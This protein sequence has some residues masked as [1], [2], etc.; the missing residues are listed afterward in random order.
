MSMIFYDAKRKLLFT[1]ILGFFLLFLFFLVQT[2]TGR[3]KNIQG[4]WEWFL[5]QILPTLS[6]MLS[7]FFANADKNAKSDKLVIDIW[8]FRIC[9]IISYVYFIVFLIVLFSYTKDKGN[10]LEYYRGFSI[11]FSVFQTLLSASLGFFFVKSHKG[12]S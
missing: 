12:N 2:I 5:P 4:H 1:W 3:Y 6:L 9:Q 10:I 8:Y 11:V 7:A